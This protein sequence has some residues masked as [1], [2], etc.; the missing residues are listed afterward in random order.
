MP[1]KLM[2]V[3]SLALM[4]LSVKVPPS[5]VL[6]VKEEKE[7]VPPP[8]HPERALRARTRLRSRI[9]RFFAFIL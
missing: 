1:Q 2:M 8:E 5:R 7:P 9:I 6:P 3:R 4:S